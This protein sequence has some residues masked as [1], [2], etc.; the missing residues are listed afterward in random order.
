MPF[1]ISTSQTWTG[2]SKLVLWCATS[3]G[4]NHF[5]NV[6]PSRS[7]VSLIHHSSAGERGW[8]H[9]DTKLG[10]LH[11]KYINDVNV[12][13]LHTNFGTSNSTKSEC[14]TKCVL[15]IILSKVWTTSKSCNYIFHYYIIWSFNKFGISTTFINLYFQCT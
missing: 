12:Y 10:L 6:I 2:K 7:N 13:P 1:F 4:N 9:S 3:S 11:S 8:R 15:A 14:W 5:G